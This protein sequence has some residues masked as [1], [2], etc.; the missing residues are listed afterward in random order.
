MVALTAEDLTGT[1]REGPGQ[2]GRRL[3]GPLV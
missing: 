2:E 1:V 3:L